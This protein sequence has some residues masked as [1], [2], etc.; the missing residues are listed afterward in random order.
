MPLLALRLNGLHNVCDQASAS[1]YLSE[2]AGGIRGTYSHDVH[3]TSS[4][5]NFFAPSSFDPKN[6]LNFFFFLPFGVDSHGSAVLELA[7]NPGISELSGW[8]PSVGFEEVLGKN[9]LGPRQLCGF[10]RLSFIFVGSRRCSV[11]RSCAR[12]DVS[13]CTLSCLWHPAYVGRL[14]LCLATHVSAR[15][16]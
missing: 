15:S 4:E 3:P 6:R 11:L 10:R 1:P 12:W 7:P 14:F 8:R 2:R 16:W 5:A 9:L 13:F